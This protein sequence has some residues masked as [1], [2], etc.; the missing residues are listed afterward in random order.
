M[1]KSSLIFRK[2]YHYKVSHIE[3]KLQN[4]R[5]RLFGNKIF[6]IKDHPTNENGMHFFRAMVTDILTSHDTAYISDRT[7]GISEILFY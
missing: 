4:I 5:N 3:N 2:G 6:C 7:L 1:M